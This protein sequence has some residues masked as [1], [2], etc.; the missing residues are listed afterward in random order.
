MQ[1]LDADLFRFLNS[2]HTDWL[3]PIMV[4]STKTHTWFPF[5]ALLILFLMFRFKAKSVSIV[6]CIT[7]LILLADQF[8]SSLMKPLFGRL[9]PCHVEDFAGWIHLP[10]G[11]AGGK[12]GFISS[13]AANTFALAAFMHRLL[14]EK[15]FFAFRVL[16]WIWAFVVSY[17]R[18]YVGVHYPGDVVFGG[19]SGVLWAFL[20]HRYV[21]PVFYGWQGFVQ[22]KLSKN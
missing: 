6:L 7:L 21:L 16:L 22:S 18:I 3:D 10:D 5:Y 1:E 13:H 17:S 4:F 8:A 9:R 19:L 14:P 20:V 2:L 11:K 12:F 15:N